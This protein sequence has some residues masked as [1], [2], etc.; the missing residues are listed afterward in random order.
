MGEWTVYF[1]SNVAKVGGMPN[2]LTDTDADAF[3][4][5]WLAAWNSHDPTRIAAHYHHDVEYDSPFVARISG[6]DAL[7]GRAAVEDYVTAG[8]ARYP[9]LHFG[10]EITVAVGSRS[11]ALVYRSVDDL[12]A[13]EVLE[14]DDAG[15]V[16]HARCHYASDAGR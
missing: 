4:R 8:L 12:L 15:L 14:L 5:S 16:T 2:L 7:H 10:P 13:V 9:D 6:G 1:K 11:V 3:A